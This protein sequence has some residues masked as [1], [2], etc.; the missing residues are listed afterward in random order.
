MTPARLSKVNHRKH[1]VGELCGIRVLYGDD[2]QTED[3]TLAV[4]ERKLLA[5]DIS[6]ICEREMKD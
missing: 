4:F 3:W 2:V 6:A 1:V 5:R